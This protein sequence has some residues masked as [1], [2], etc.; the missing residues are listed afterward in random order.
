M[1]YQDII[2]GI[3]TRLSSINP[4][5]AII[6]G[7]YAHGEPSL[8]S[9]ID[10]IVVLNKKGFPADYNEMMENHRTVRKLLRDINRETALDIIVYTIDEWESFIKTGSY[11]SRVVLEKGKA[12]A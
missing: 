3:A 8:D 9:D 5:K 1:N 4:Y 6:F 7:S 12:I 10:I 11:F 2:Q